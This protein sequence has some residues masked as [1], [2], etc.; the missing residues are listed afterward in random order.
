MPTPAVNKV[1]GPRVKGVR[2]ASSGNQSAGADRMKT[3]D[4]PLDHDV[5]DRGDTCPV[6]DMVGIP[7]LVSR[8]RPSM[9]YAANKDTFGF[10]LGSNYFPN[11]IV[12]KF[13]ICC[14]L[15]L[16]REE[17]SKLFEA[18][19]RWCKGVGSVVV[20]RAD[21][22]PLYVHHVRALLDFTRSVLDLDALSAGLKYAKRTKPSIPVFLGTGYFYKG[23]TPEE[24]LAQFTPGDFKDHYLR[25]R[26]LWHTVAE[27]GNTD[28]ELSSPWTKFNTE[29]GYVWTQRNLDRQAYGK[30]SLHKKVSSGWR[31]IDLL[32]HIERLLEGHSD[33]LRILT[34]EMY[35]AK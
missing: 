7:L 12:Q 20:V 26:Y 18:P 16:A 5:F 27:E 35:S 32:W 9:Q 31:Q 4:V 24:I 29:K 2:I 15:K 11:P 22:K 1:V 3:V 19:K 28:V 34:K 25:E 17:D 8:V 33:A 30:M 23:R 10:D 6:S 13:M 14:D 21:R